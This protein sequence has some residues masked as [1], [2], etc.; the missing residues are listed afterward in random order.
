[1]ALERSGGQLRILV[2]GAVAASGPDSP[3]S[4]TQT[5][6]FQLWLGERLDGAQHLSGALD[7]S[8]LFRRALST[9]DLTAVRA[10]KPVSGAVM[11]LRF[12]R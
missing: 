11:E 10:G 1:M 6:S 5:V 12:D 3:G 8:R 2:D 4:V 9:A 7:D